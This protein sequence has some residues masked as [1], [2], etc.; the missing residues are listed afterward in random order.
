MWHAPEPEQLF[1]SK[2]S[3]AYLKGGLC[4]SEVLLFHHKNI[5]YLSA[6][7]RGGS[8]FSLENIHPFL[9]G[10][11]KRK[12]HKILYIMFGARKL[13]QNMYGGPFMVR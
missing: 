1:S 11:L 5:F 4:M 9:G 2:Y 12:P 7:S 13:N 8:T 6:A 10:P 3:M